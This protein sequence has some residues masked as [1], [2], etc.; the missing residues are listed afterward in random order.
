MEAARRQDE[1]KAMPVQP[2]IT[3]VSKR[4]TDD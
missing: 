2:N 1:K 3:E 4:C